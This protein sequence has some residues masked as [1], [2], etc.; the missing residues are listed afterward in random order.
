M[1]RILLV[2]LALTL[3]L[4][5]QANA[6]V[7]RN[8][9]PGDQIVGVTGFQTFGNEMAG[10]LVTAN[11][12]VGSQAAVWAAT[13][14][15]AGAAGGLYGL[16]S[17]SL[18]VAGDT[19]SSPWVLVNNTGVAIT[20]IF[21]DPFPGNTVFDTI[22]DPTLTPFSERGGANFTPQPFQTAYYSS[23]VSVLGD[24]SS[25]YGDLYRYLEVV[26]AGGLPCQGRTSWLADTD[27]I[28]FPQTPIPGSLLLLGSGLV[29][30]VGL[31]LRRR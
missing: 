2:L 27:T 26:F 3:V 7:F 12:A 29:G 28:G 15:T 11:F 24:A 5:V 25:P 10:M 16:G 21:I 9:L 20:S 8:P 19:F 23:E 4:A 31:R 6:D 13:G 30:L 1:K 18:S 17:W 22:L 14:A